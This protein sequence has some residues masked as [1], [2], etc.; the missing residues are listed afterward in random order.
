MKESV[1]LYEKGN[2]WVKDT[3]TRYE[4]IANKTC[5]GELDSAYP[6]N[7]DGLSIAK[8]RTNYLANK[9]PNP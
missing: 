3:K 6:K 4:V 2:Y 5:Y 9:K 7:P 1:I 8:A